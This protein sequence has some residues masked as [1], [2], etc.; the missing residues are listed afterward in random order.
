MKNLNQVFSR[1]EELDVILLIDEGDALLTR[2]TS[3]NTSNDRYAN[4]E[5]NFLFQREYRKLGAV[6]PLRA[7]LRNRVVHA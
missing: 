4:L 5:T 6:C 1:A 3:V 2:R 7:S